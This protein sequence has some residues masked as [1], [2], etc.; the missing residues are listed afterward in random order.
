MKLCWIFVGR[1]M[2]GTWASRGF[3]PATYGI[4]AQCATN[5]AITTVLFARFLCT[6]V[7]AK[8]RHLSL[9]LFWNRR[10]HSLSS[11]PSS[12]SSSEAGDF[13]FLTRFL[14]CNRPPDPGPPPLPPL[15]PGPEPESSFF[16]TKKLKKSKNWSQIDYKLMM[17]VQPKWVIIT[18][19]L[20]PAQRKPC[21]YVEPWKNPPGR[22]YICRRVDSGRNGWVQTG[23]ATRCCRI[24]TVGVAGWELCRSSAA[25]QANQTSSV[26]DRSSLWRNSRSCKISKIFC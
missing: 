8:I 3:E 6:K 5:W 26:H 1:K 13:G 18:G 17:S 10:S 20:L 4:Q 25:T 9:A 14:F 12:S 23:N 16:L 2:G 19:V 11:F 21:C 22:T 7:A 24:V 15:L